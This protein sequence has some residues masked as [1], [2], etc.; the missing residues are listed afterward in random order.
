M[1]SDMRFVKGQ[2]TRHK[3]LESAM[4]I[5]AQ[6]GFSGLSAKKI[7]DGAGISKSNVFHH[8]TSTDEILLSL[9]TL[10]TEYITAPLPEVELFTLEDFFEVLGE[11]TFDIDVKD[12]LAYRVLFQ[13]YNLALVDCDYKKRILQLRRDLASSLAATI[14]SISPESKSRLDDLIDLIVISLDAL[15]M[16]FLIEKDKNKYITLWRIQYKQYI[17]FLQDN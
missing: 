9:F 10:I 17:R 12:E 8:F 4:F 15:G 14:I 2:E 1:S 5:L 6:D 13:F 16:H 11:S 3:I 7:S